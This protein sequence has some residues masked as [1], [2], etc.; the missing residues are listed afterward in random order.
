MNVLRENR[1]Y[2]HSND[3][4]EPADNAFRHNMAQNI[5]LEARPRETLV[6]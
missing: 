5:N 3:V 4:I 2:Y 6:R 1:R